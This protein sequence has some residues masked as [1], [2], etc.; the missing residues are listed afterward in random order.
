M[1]G[2]C[3]ILSIEIA[4]SCFKRR[5]EPLIVCSAPPG[6]EERSR[7]YEDR[8][9]SHAEQRI[10]ELEPLFRGAPEATVVFSAE[11]G[12]HVIE[13]T[14]FSGS[15]VFRVVEKTSD[16]M[17]S[18]DA[19]A[20]SIRRQL[21][22]HH[23]QLTESVNPDAFEKDADDLIFIPEVDKFDAP[24]YQVVRSK[25]FEFGPMSVQDAILQ[26]NLIGHSF[27][28]FRNEDRD[29]AFSVVYRRNDGGYGV[30]VDKR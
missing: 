23:N 27:F 9:Y 12:K 7:H 6:A 26:M 29:G 22:E 14:I 16:M 19:A 24:A 21:R 15:T 13:L 4:K 20:S 25:E 2:Q 18:I 10:N 11:N 30:L 5:S 8:V 1:R 28:A 17:V 3:V